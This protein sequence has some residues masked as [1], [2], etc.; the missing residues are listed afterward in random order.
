MRAIVATLFV[1]ACAAVRHT[2]SSPESTQPGL[3]YPYVL[4]S[5]R[6]S[7]EDL[8]WLRD[9][10]APECVDSSKTQMCECIGGKA[11]AKWPGYGIQV[12]MGTGG[13]GHWQRVAGAYAMLMWD[14]G[15]YIWFM[16]QPVPKKREETPQDTLP[17]PRSK[18]AVPPPP[19]KEALPPPAPQEK[20][21]LRPPR[22]KGPLPLAKDMMKPLLGK[23][24]TAGSGGK[25]WALPPD[26]LDA[27]SFWAKLGTADSTDSAGSAETGSM[28]LSGG[29]PPPV[30][31]RGKRVLPDSFWG[32]AGPP[33][34]DMSGTSGKAEQ[35]WW[36]SVDDQST[37]GS[38]R[39]S[40]QVSTQRSELSVGKSP[41]P[42]K[43]K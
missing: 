18:H 17:P 9:F 21:A 35:S 13:L 8:E 7:E 2:G 24:P 40:T 42:P 11:T 29:K 27:D 14:E 20:E 30:V 41:P 10:A 32:S 6:M 16:R 37:Q 15:T 33:K 1:S 38:T 36:S 22:A 34:S 39:R 43:G 23:A 3:V 31:V 4:R 5:A 25:S 28:E 12:M 26:S 19:E